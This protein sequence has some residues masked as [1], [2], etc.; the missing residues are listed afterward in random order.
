M[1]LHATFLLTHNVQP[2]LCCAHT[3]TTRSTKVAINF[4]TATIREIYFHFSFTMQS[5]GQWNWKR[6]TFSSQGPRHSDPR[7]ILSARAHG[8][9]IIV[10]H[11]NQKFLSKTGCRTKSSVVFSIT[12]FHAMQAI[13]QISRISMKHLI[14][15]FIPRSTLVRMHIQWV[16][17]RRLMG[18]SSREENYC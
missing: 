14:V 5:V 18:K 15:P 12:V 2:V 10:A 11:R 7:T 1:R 4:T 9:R 8:K 6:S 17:A 13:C 16:V 3:T